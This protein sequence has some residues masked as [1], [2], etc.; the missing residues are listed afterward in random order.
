[1]WIA[2]SRALI[3]GELL[4]EQMDRFPFIINMKTARAVGLALPPALLAR[5][6]E[7]IE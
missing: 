1:M 3:P 7:A 6:D 4:V 5:A 2:S